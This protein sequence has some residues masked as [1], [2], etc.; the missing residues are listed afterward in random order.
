MTLNIIFML[1]VGCIAKK[2]TDL[3]RAHQEEHFDI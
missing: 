2:T 1:I 3:E